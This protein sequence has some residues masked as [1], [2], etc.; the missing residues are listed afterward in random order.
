MHIINNIFIKWQYN[1][2]VGEGGNTIENERVRPITKSY[3]HAKCVYR[4]FSVRA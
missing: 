1:E 4:P 2:K 3:S